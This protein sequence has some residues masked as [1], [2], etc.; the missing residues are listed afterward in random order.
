MNRPAQRWRSVALLALA[1]FYPPFF[2]LLVE[3]LWRHGSVS[4]KIN[5]LLLFI[6]ILPHIAL[7]FLGAYRMRALVA[8]VFMHCIRHLLEIPSYYCT[9]AIAA[10]KSIF[11]GL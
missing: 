4:N 10:E 5:L 3:L 7:A 11:V 2:G 9:A 8:A 6:D 1:V